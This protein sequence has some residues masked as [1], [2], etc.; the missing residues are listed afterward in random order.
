MSATPTKYRGTGVITAADYKAVKWVGKT[1]GGVAITIEMPKAINLGNIDWAFAEKDDT[2]A[3]IVMTA[4]YANTDSTATD[5]TEP[6]TVDVADSITKAADAIMLGAGIFY[7]GSTA[8]ALTRGGGKFS[9]EREYREIAAD[10]DRG[11]V[12]GR[13]ELVGSRASLT[14]NTLQILTRLTDL[15]PAIETVPAT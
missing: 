10:G 8:I 3:E 13:I 12:E 15:Y 5:T 11:P 6:W 14:M 2:V 1:K 9:V 7:V 4:V